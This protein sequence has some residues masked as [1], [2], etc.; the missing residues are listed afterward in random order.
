M[1]TAGW[2]AKPSRQPSFIGGMTNYFV[3]R[4]GFD[5]VKKWSPPSPKLSRA[6]KRYRDFRAVADV[7]PNFKS[8]LQYLSSRTA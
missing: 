7:F 8:Y 4:A 6:Q 1:V 3:T 2:M 5:A